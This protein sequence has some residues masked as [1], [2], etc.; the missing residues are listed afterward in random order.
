MPRTSPSARALRALAPEALGPGVGG[1]RGG[2]GCG[3]CLRAVGPGG[4]RVGVDVDQGGVLGPTIHG[5]VTGGRLSLGGRARLTATEQQGI[6]HGTEPLGNGVDRCGR[7]HQQAEGHQADQPQVG[8][9]DPDGGHDRCGDEPADPPAGRTHRLGPVTRARRS[10][11]QRPDPACRCQQ[12]PGADGQ[13]AGGGCLVRVAQHAQ[14][15]PE[16]EQRDDDI[17]G[18]EQAGDDRRDDPGQPPVDGEPGHRGHDDGQGEQQQAD[19]IATVGGIQVPG[20]AT[21]SA[22][23]ASED[24]RE[25]QPDPGEEPPERP[26]HPCDGARPAARGRLGGGPRDRARR[27]T[28]GLG[29]S[30]RALAAA[31]LGAA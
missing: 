17:Q 2:G 28:P 27:G 13:T 12:D 8:K 21:H 15:G 4:G 23:H 29:G 6:A 26:H 24:R 1:G 3:A 30:G 25:E 5:H 16:Q 22:R 9:P 20:A 14:R 19:A 10:L 11:G 18:A 31:R 7:D